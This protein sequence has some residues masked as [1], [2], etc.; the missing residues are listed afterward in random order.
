MIPSISCLRSLFGMH[1]QPYCNCL[2]ATQRIATIW[3]RQAPLI[4]FPDLAGAVDDT[5]LAGRVRHSGVLVH[6]LSWH[7]QRTVAPELILGCAA[8]PPTGYE[9][10]PS[11]SAQPCERH[12]GGSSRSW[13][14]PFLATRRW[15]GL[16]GGPEDPAAGFV[17]KC[18]R[19][20]DVDVGGGVEA[21]AGFGGQVEGQRAEI[22]Q[23][24]VQAS[25][26]NNRVDQR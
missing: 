14:C 22:F 25:G 7:P 12:F 26:A 5:D 11:A 16:F 20:A 4:T 10:P 23:E 17:D 9:R 24:L 2:V 3:L 19:E 8:Y 6:P 1:D 21:L 13:T 18:H 15:S